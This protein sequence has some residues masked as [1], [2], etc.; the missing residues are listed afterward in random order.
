MRIP[1]FLVLL[2]SFQISFG[3]NA[4]IDSIRVEIS[5]AKSD[6]AKISGINALAFA[7]HQVQPDSTIVIAEQALKLSRS[8][9]YFEGMAHAYYVSA[10]G[11][12]IE[13]KYDTAIY[14]L[15]KSNQLYDSIG[16]ETPPFISNATGIVYRNLGH[17]PQAHEQHLIALR[18]YE[19]K[20]D[21]PGIAKVISNIGYIYFNEGEYTK[22][23]LNYEKS[24]EIEKG[25]NQ[26]NRDITYNNIGEVYEKRKKY[27]RALDYYHKGLEI[28]KEN[29]HVRNIGLIYNSIGGVYNQQGNF[30]KA[31]VYYQKSLEAK[32]QID[33]EAGIAQTMN[34]IGSVHLKQSNYTVSQKYLYDALIKAQ[35][36][37]NVQIAERAAKN[38][39][40]LQK[41]KGDFAAA[42]Q[43]H[44][45]FLEL[46]DSLF[47]KEKTRKLARMEAEYAFERE[48]REIAFRAKQK[49]IEW[50]ATQKRLRGQQ[51][52][53]LIAILSAL[54]LV[55]VTIRYY[56]IKRQANQRLIELNETINARNEEITSQRD[57][58]A[59][60]G[61]QLEKK[62]RTLTKLNED[63]NFLIGVVAHDLKSPL[64]HIKGLLNIVQMSADKLPPDVNNFHDKMSQSAERLSLMISRILDVNAIENRHIDVKLSTMEVKPLL[65][66]ITEE[67][68]TEAKEKGIRLKTELL[69]EQYICV[70]PVYFQQII[71]NLISNAIKFSPKL[72]EVT[73]LMRNNRGKVQIHV[74]DEGPGISNRDQR[75]LFRSYQRLSAKPTGDEESTGLGLAVVK[76]FTDFMQGE[77]WCE[78]NLG[79]GATFILQFEQVVQHS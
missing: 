29:K 43:Y 73:V 30:D 39:Y 74:K 65:L 26:F 7:Y 32:T 24:I 20:K 54:V 31:L 77:I 10:V 68:E 66:L 58:L 9:Q 76:K 41:K 12:A 21:G 40:I 33:D 52:S 71:E 15:Q 70:D 36:L 60:Q 62:N 78:S 35:A 46:R 45:T 28:A 42:L 47:S 2:L 64:N 57:Q 67:F 37:G 53:A 48:K 23:L 16:V 18:K 59:E 25:I 61:I 38:L 27:E 44:E 4:Y 56:L 14:L 11:F 79:S 22:A 72:K 17:Y 75:K 13:S 5:K 49:E 8:I 51:V 3:Q 19:E 69:E 34:A 55:T 63:K 50:G 1:V 6:T